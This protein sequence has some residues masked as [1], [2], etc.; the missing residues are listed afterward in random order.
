[1]QPPA[2]PTGLEE[3]PGD[4]EVQRQIAEILPIE[5]SLSRRSGTAEH[6]DL[7]TYSTIDV[8]AGGPGHTSCSLGRAMILY[9]NRS[10]YGRKAERGSG[11]KP[12]S[13]ATPM[14]HRYQLGLYPVWRALGQR[15]IQ[16]IYQL[17]LPATRLAVFVDARITADS[18]QVDPGPSTLPAGEAVAAN[19]DGRCP[20]TST[21]CVVFGRRSAAEA[22][23]AKWPNAPSG[24]AA[25]RRTLDDLLAAGLIDDPQ[26]VSAKITIVAAASG[27]RDE[28][29]QSNNGSIRPRRA[30]RWLPDLPGAPLGLGAH[31]VVLEAEQPHRRSAE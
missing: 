14:F 21:R 9:C 10:S 7:H 13:F 1:M 18:Q 11:R 31:A 5:S 27:A 26:I 15:R 20:S 19:D 3:R 8:P 12:S 24:A 23:G 17:H 16:R 6:L 2:C 25:V 29:H 4:A 28:R 22:V 30:A